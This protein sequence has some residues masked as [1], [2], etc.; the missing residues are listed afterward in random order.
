MAPPDTSLWQFPTLT[1]TY[2]TRS[3]TH[4]CYPQ[5]LCGKLQ[6]LHEKQARVSQ[7]VTSVMISHSMLLSD[8]MSDPEC[9]GCEFGPGHEGKMK[10]HVGKSSSRK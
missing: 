5:N 2:N 7:G 10:A 4:A 1:R 6:A 3:A 8:R 9:L